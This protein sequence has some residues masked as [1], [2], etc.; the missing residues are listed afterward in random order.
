MGRGSARGAFAG[1]VLLLAS[2]A[3]ALAAAE[4]IVRV[5]APAAASRIEYPCFYEPDE[6][7]GFHYLPYGRGTVSGHFEIDHTVELNSLGFYDDEPLPGSPGLRVLAVGDSFTAALNVARDEVWTSVLERELRARGYPDADVVNIGLDGTGTDVHLELLRRYVPRF[8]PQVV[9]LAFFAN[10]PEDVEVGRFTRECYRGYVLSYQTAEQQGRLRARV[11]AESGRRGLRWLFARSLLARLALVAW[12]GP[13]TLLRLNFVQPSR[14]ELGLTPDVLASRADR[15]RQS[16]EALAR[17]ASQCECALLVAPVPARRE[18][19][20]SLE[21]ARSVARGLPLEIVDVLPGIR[22]RL[23]AAGKSPA[24][25]FFVHDAHLNAWGN[26]V[27]AE[28]LADA[29]SWPP[30]RGR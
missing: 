23:A 10:D 9:V 3:F 17:F 18:L 28:A 11:D 13:R 5:L 2:L 4:G 30:P 29:V 8:L 12:E 24:D 25:L 26:R 22:A 14:A 21:L 1:P 27:F 16:F 7:L 15:P 6:A 19:G 20:A